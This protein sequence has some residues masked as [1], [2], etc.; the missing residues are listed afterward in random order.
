MAKKRNKNI[1]TINQKVKKKMTKDD[2]LDFL[3]PFVL[4]LLITLFLSFVL[5]YR[6]EEN[7]YQKVDKLEKRIEQLEKT[8]NDESKRS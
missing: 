3:K 4:I 7:V 6:P 2:L 5:F 8:K 1:L